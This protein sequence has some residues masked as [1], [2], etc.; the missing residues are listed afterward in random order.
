MS[1]SGT[2]TQRKYTAQGQELWIQDTE[3]AEWFC[4]RGW[5]KTDEIRQWPLQTDDIHPVDAEYDTYS[6]GMG[7]MK[8][9]GRLLLLAIAMFVSVVAGIVVWLLI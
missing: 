6:D 5:T 3:E 2:F 9:L 1:G 4:S 8:M 7:P